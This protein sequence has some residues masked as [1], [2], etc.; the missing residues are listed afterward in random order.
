MVLYHSGMILT[1]RAERTQ[2]YD[3]MV[4]KKITYARTNGTYHTA[5]IPTVEL[6]TIKTGL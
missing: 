5:K 2:R 4:E 3:N 6:P 1:K